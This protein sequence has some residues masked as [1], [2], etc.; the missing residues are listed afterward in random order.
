MNSEVKLEL[1]EA[2]LFSLSKYFLNACY[3]LGP[4]GWG[5]GVLHTRTRWTRCL[6]A[7]DL[8]TFMG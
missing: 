4:G 6:T 3:V 7:L 1:C 2:I 5:W 8:T